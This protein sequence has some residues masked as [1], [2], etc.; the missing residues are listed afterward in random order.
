MGEPCY[1]S[2]L[3]KRD[4]GAISCSARFMPPN[5]GYNPTMSP[6][7]HIAI[8]TALLDEDDPVASV[9]VV[10]AILEVLSA[11]ESE[12]IIIIGRP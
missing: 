11:L 2:D 12:S 4:R 8:R 7:T 6:Q 3:G 10:D 5:V 9:D 1:R